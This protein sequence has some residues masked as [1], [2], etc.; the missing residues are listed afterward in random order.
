MSS[1]AKFATL[2]SLI[3]SKDIS[4]ASHTLD[5]KLHQTPILKLVA[6]ARAKGYDTVCLPLTTAKWKDRW[7]DMCLLPVGASI[8]DRDIAAEERA[9]AWRSDP[10]FL[11][12]EVTMTRL[13][14]CLAT[15]QYLYNNIIR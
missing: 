10:T 13:G 2:S 15:L 4:T 11:L 6:D 3:T 14:A 12:D 9:E 7:V 5:S 1:W 8:R